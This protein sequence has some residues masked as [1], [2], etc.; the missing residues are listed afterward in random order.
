MLLGSGELRPEKLLRILKVSP[1]IETG[2][3]AHSAGLRV[4][5]MPTV[6]S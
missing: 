3:N 2:P 5:R 4:A 1:A 6:V